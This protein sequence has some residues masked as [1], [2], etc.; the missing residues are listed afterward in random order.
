MDNIFKFPKSNMLKISF[1]ETPSAKKTKEI[2]LLR[3][4]MSIPPH[5]VELE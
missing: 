3:F 4:S 1:N 5:T 2:G